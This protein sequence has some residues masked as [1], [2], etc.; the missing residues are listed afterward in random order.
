MANSPAGFSHSSCENGR[1]AGR[2][3]TTIRRAQVD[4]ITPWF[5]HQ[6]DRALRP[7][8]LRWPCEAT[9]LAGIKRP[10]GAL[11]IVAPRRS[12]GQFP[13]EEGVP[14]RFFSVRLTALMV[15]LVAVGGR[16]VAA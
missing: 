16:P 7:E 8:A 13:W 15:A 11:E 6:T 3:C 10:S 1:R 14:M 5:S 2:S 9:K 4:D 12:V